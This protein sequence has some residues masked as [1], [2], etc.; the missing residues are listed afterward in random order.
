MKQFVLGYQTKIVTIF[1][2]ISLLI[3]AGLALTFPAKVA[4][5]G[6]VFSSRQ[7]LRFQYTL[8][9]NSPWAELTFP[10]DYVAVTLSQQEIVEEDGMLFLLAQGSFTSDS[11]DQFWL[12]VR[13]WFTLTDQTDLTTPADAFPHLD[14]DYSHQLVN[15]Q[16]GFRL[17]TTQVASDMTSL[18]DFHAPVLHKD[19]VKQL[20]LLALFE[21][22]FLLSILAVWRKAPVSPELTDRLRTMAQPLPAEL[23][24]SGYRKYRNFY[25]G[26]TTISL[27]LRFV[28]LILVYCFLGFT[29]SVSAAF[30]AEILLLLLLVAFLVQRSMLFLLISNCQLEELKAILCVSTEPEFSSYLW[31][32]ISV[33]KMTRDFSLLSLLSQ[34]LRLEGQPRQALELLDL[35]YQETSSSFYRTK[36]AQYHC[37]RCQLLLDLQEHRLS[38]HELVLLELELNQIRWV[39]PGERRILRRIQLLY[40]LMLAMVEQR[41]EDA[42]PLAATLRADAGS[43]NQVKACA[44]QYPIARALDNQ[45][46]AQDC[47]VSIQRYAPAF[48][49]VLSQAKK[50]Q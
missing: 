2:L 28:L 40:R 9:V 41:W 18:L 47:L 1:I 5:R 21:L 35:C 45:A 39:R 50:P 42:Q 44:L 10:E 3:S 7:T 26:V 24:R 6:G 16:L 13:D 14:G 20:A 46:L 49:A 15:E 43:L 11:T 30:T 31:D 29:K 19:S 48:A 25:C 34:A 36:K 8:R 33:H 38:T 22:F 23:R 12:C 32:G 17:E 4:L 27:L 37:Q